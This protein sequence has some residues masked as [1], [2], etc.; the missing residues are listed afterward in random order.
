MHAVF[1]K[2]LQ[3]DRGKKY[4]REHEKDYDEQSVNLKLN[5]FYT[6]SNNARVSASTT[7]IYMTSAKIES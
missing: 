3:T 7:L 1:D 5:S 6:E 4:V 2:K